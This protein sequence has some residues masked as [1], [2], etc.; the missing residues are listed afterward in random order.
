MACVAAWR[1]YLQQHGEDCLQ[2]RGL[3]WRWDER[4]WGWA[5]DLD[6]LKGKFGFSIKC[7]GNLIIDGSF[8]TVT[9]LNVLWLLQKLAKAVCIKSPFLHISKS[10]VLEKTGWQT[11]IEQTRWK[12]G[13]KKPFLH[14]KSANK[15]ALYVFINNWFQLV[16]IIINLRLMM[17]HN[18]IG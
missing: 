11:L 17:C 16:I 9:F 13:L 18:L 14:L 2:R 1:I 6:I 5:T 10:H 8:L 7:L 15:R 3:F 4:D 12:S